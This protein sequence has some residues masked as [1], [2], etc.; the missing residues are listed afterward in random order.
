[1]AWRDEIRPG[2]TALGLVLY[3]AIRYVT[4]EERGIIAQIIRVHTLMP[5]IR[6]LLGKRVLRRELQ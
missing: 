4:I 2:M 5:D 3:Q 1:M 6:R